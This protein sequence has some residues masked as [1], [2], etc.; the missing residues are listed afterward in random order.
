VA[1]NRGKWGHGP[2]PEKTSPFSLVFW[3]ADLSHKTLPLHSRSVGKKGEDKE[4][5]RRSQVPEPLSSLNQ[6]CFVDYLDT[7]LATGDYL[8]RIND[9]ASNAFSIFKIPCHSDF[10]TPSK[11]FAEVVGELQQS[12]NSEQVLL[13]VLISIF[14]TVL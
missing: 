11:V 3:P 8:K 14:L 2:K 12:N 10:Y 9:Y 6:C 5:K 7:Y 1:S 4:A 13:L